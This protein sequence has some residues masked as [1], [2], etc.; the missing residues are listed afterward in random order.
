M[1][2]DLSQSEL[3]TAIEA[4]AMTQS[5]QEMFMAQ[6]FAGARSGRHSRDR[7]PRGRAR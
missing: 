5:I 1:L 6:K 2:A 7:L 4:T 3:Q